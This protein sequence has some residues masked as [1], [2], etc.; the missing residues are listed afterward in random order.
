MCAVYGLQ[1]HGASRNLVHPLRRKMMNDTLHRILLAGILT[2][3][4]H[5]VARGG[6]VGQP[7]TTVQRAALA[8]Q[9]AEANMTDNVVILPSFNYASHPANIV[10]V[11]LGVT[12]TFS[13][14]SVFAER[15]IWRHN[16][17]TIQGHVTKHSPKGHY[18]RLTSSLNTSQL[19]I[20]NMTRDAAGSV[21]CL[22][23]CHNDTDLCVLRQFELQLQLR[24]E[25][26]F[27]EPMRNVSTPLWSFSMKCSGFVDCS[28]TGAQAHFIWKFDDRFLTAPYRYLRTIAQKSHVDGLLSTRIS[29]PVTEK[30][31]PVCSS[32]LTIRLTE[33]V[34]NR[35]AR[36]DCWLRTDVRRHEWFVQSAYVHFSPFAALDDTD[37]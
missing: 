1:W 8:V 6:S 35:S 4:P 24:V 7:L 31:D 12:A 9:Q 14:Y 26:V 22:L 36:V 29:Y 2:T 18:Y 33:V 25:D 37:L 21:E 30:G 11:P 27:T 32:T 13:C 15:V 3:V 10:R 16:N 28:Q 19:L 17:I 5:R 20:H 23:S 34:S